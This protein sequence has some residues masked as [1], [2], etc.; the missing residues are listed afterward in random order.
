MKVIFLL[1]IF[2]AKVAT[3]NDYP[4][5]FR[6]QVLTTDRTTSTV[7]ATSFVTIP[8]IINALHTKDFQAINATVTL[9]HDWEKP[10]FTAWA[11][12]DKPNQYSLNFWGGLAR[13]PGMNDEG[14]ALTACHEVGHILGGTPRIKIPQFLWSSAEGQS[15]YYATSKCLKTYFKYLHQTVK[16]KVP[17]TLSETAFTLCRTSFAQ[18]TDFLVCLNTHKG[19]EA[20]AA[21]LMHLTQYEREFSIETPSRERVRETMFDSYPEPQCRLDTLVAGALGNPRPGCWFRN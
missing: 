2:W 12:Q 7:T 1:F 6:Y 9:T 8:H 4:E 21:M 3:A 14:M 11:A 15:D 10:F 18:E 5:H 16:L 13:I 20:F 17:Q 19:I